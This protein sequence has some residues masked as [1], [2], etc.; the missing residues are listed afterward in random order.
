MHAVDNREFESRCILLPNELSVQGSDP[1]FRRYTPR[2][3][4]LHN[5]AD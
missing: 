4:M 3:D 5:D 2:R 1:E